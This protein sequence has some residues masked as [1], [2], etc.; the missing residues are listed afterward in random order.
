MFGLGAA[1][2]QNYIFGLSMGGYGAMKCALTYPDRYA[3]AAFRASVICAGRSNAAHVSLHESEITA[4]FGEK[5]RSAEGRSLR[6]G[7]TALR[8]CPGTVSVLW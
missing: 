8:G 6:P 3:G 2:E 1:R 4:I 7:G 5:N